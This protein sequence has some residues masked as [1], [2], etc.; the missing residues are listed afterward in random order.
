MKNIFKTFFT[1]LTIV[2]FI[3][4][5]ETTDNIEKLKTCDENI[6]NCEKWILIQDTIPSRAG[7]GYKSGY[8]DEKGDTV[9]PL[10]RYI[11]YTEKFEYYAIVF[12][13]ENNKLIGINKA[14]EKLFDAVFTTEMDPMP[15]SNGRLLIVANDKYGY[16]NHKGEIVIKPIYSCAESFH[17]GKARVS[18]QCRPSK[19]EHYK[20]ESDN[21]IYID[22]CGNEISSNTK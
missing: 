12:D 8:V 11:C 7:F 14:Q 19:D 18:N 5:C 9:I 10:D 17:D 6:S 21:W 22:K 16:A 3:L 1:L 4:S 13:I 2:L 20:W 15:E